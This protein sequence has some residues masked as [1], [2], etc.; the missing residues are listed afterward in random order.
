MEN[1]SGVLR[2][3]FDHNPAI[4][5]ALPLLNS[6]SYSSPYFLNFRSKK[7]KTYGNQT[8]VGN[9][10]TYVTNH[11]AFPN[12]QDRLAV[13]LSKDIVETLLYLSTH[14]IP[15][16]VA[17]IQL[18]AFYFTPQ[19]ALKFSPLASCV[20]ASSAADISSYTHKCHELISQIAHRGTS[21]VPGT[22]E[23]SFSLNLYLTSLFIAIDNLQNLYLVLADA[24]LDLFRIRDVLAST[25]H[26]SQG[27]VRLTPASYLKRVAQSLLV[28]ALGGKELVVD[29][30]EQVAVAENF[31]DSYLHG[32]ALGTS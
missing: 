6:L 4:S 13:A 9:L 1:N 24:S 18:D 5:D 27:D 3:I 7:S 17:K 16:D 31:D 11:S 26:A 15:C 25:I 19:L 8:V 32:I 23:I 20:G 12:I 22:N 28:D 30:I 21:S 2:V 10:H 14:S 29:I